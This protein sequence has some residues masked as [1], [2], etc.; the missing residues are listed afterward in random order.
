MMHVNYV[1]LKKSFKKKD[2]Y[3]NLQEKYFKNVII[4]FCETVICFQQIL[5]THSAYSNNE[6]SAHY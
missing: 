3:T 4:F 1:N 6:K 5:I 2:M